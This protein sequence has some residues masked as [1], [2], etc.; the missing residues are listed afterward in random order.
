[1]NAGLPRIL[2]K[3]K[4]GIIDII[5]FIIKYCL[6]LDTSELFVSEKMSL[7]NEIKN[8]NNCS[9]GFDLMDFFTVDL[10]ANNNM[11]FIGGSGNTPAE[12]TAPSTEKKNNAP[13]AANN[14][15]EKKKDEKPMSEKEK[16]RILDSEE[17]LRNEEELEKDADNELKKE[18]EQ[19]NEIEKSVKNNVDSKLNNSVSIDTGK[20]GEESVGG[21]LIKL[22]TDTIKE[23]SVTV[24][25]KVKA[26][27]MVFIYA[28]V[29]PA[30]P[31][32]AVMAAMF[33]TLKYLF[34][35]FR[36]F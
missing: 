1:M 2:A 21:D 9:G 25:R 14:K 24:S 19:K 17:K 12:A 22:I 8:N 27:C 32:F 30:V 6:L 35:K 36:V 34:F 4:T 13:P 31:F 11:F 28:S 23:G 16:Q 15:K 3:K 29:Y 10:S 18:E 5:V 7:N 20:T 26:F 33:A